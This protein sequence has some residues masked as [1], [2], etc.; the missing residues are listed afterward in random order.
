MANATARVARDFRCYKDENVRHS[1]GTLAA[2]L[3]LYSGAMVGMNA[4]YLAKFDDTAS[5]KFFGIV[6]DNEN[7]GGFQGPKVPNNGAASG[8]AGDGTLD[9]DVK[10]PPRFV[11]AI[12]GVTI[13]DIGRR[14]YALDDQTGTLDPSATTYANQVG[15]VF[16]L[17]YNTNPGSPVSGY[18]VVKPIYDVPQGAQLQVVGASG[19]VVIKPSTVLI[20][21]AGV[22]ALTIADPTSGLHDG[23][24]MTFIS[25]TAQAHT[26]DNS[27]GSGFNAGGAGTDV[28]TFGGAKG[29]NIQIVAYGGKW[30]VKNKT[31]VNLG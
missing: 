11:L 18:A 25:A 2:P 1:Y 8:T 4:G 23:L 31:N 9:L 7:S 21:K 24:E 13:A 6:I 15:T 14:V 28:G 19:A 10:Q 29:D 22:A 16:D 12:A 17:V 30:L 27:A 26:L 5:L 3:Q 20:T